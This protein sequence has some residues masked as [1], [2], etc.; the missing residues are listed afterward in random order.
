MPDIGQRP[1]GQRGQRTRE[2]V[3]PMA[4]K[5]MHDR[6][7]RCGSKQ[8]SR[9]LSAARG[10][11]ASAQSVRHCTQSSPGLRTSHGLPGPV[12][13]FPTANP[14]KSSAFVGIGKLSHA[15]IRLFPLLFG[16]LMYTI[17]L[18]RWVHW[19]KIALAKHSASS[20]PLMMSPQTRNCRETPR[21]QKYGCR[22]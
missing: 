9:L 2:R 19:G 15:Q 21:C 6:S 3:C 1:D 7:L 12:S 4:R 5:Q 16:I 22:H 18:I 17:F 20:R 13:A 14:Q 11:P 8:V 10:S